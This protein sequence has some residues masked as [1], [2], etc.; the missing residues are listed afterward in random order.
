[1]A[2]FMTTAIINPFNT[3]NKSEDRKNFMSG[4][5]S[6]Y[7]IFLVFMFFSYKINFDLIICF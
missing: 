4:D 3:D 5:I 7:I 6:F 1:M 2:C